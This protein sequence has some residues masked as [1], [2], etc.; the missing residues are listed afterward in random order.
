MG[1][2]QN[3]PDL[4]LTNSRGHP[5]FKIGES[6]LRPCFANRP[7]ADFS[8]V[9][10]S[11]YSK[12]SCLLD[13]GS[14]LNILGQSGFSKIK[15]L[16]IPYSRKFS[17]PS[18]RAV[19]GSRLLVKGVIQL[20]LFWAGHP[21]NC[22]AYI[23]PSVKQDL[24]LGYR[25][26]QDVGLIVDT[27]NDTYSFLDS[28]GQR[29][30]VSI[31][32][33]CLAE[34]VPEIAGVVAE[35]TNSFVTPQAFQVPVWDINHPNLT[36]S[37]SLEVID[38]LTNAFKEAPKGLGRTNVLVN[39][40]SL[41]DKTP[42]K[43]RQ[44]PLSFKA[45]ENANKTVD[46][47]LAL[48]CIRP[49]KSPF[50]NPIWMVNQSSSGRAD[51]LVLDARKLNERTETDCY[52]SPLMDR[53]LSS[54]GRPKFISK[55][56]L[57]KAFMQICLDE[58]SKPY[59]AFAVP[60]RGLFE[61]N[62][63]P[64]GLKNGPPVMQRLIE[65]IFGPEFEPHL[66][67]YLDDLILLSEDFQSHLNLLQTVFDRLKE[68]NLSINW[69]KSQFCVPSATF[70]GFVVSEEGVGLDRDRIAPILDLPAPNSKKKVKSFV[71]CCSFY[72]KH[73][74][75]FAEISAPLTRLTSAKVP[76]LWDDECQNSFEKLKQC[77]TSAPI[78]SNPI[79]G[80][81]WILET[82]ASDRSFGG[83]LLQEQ[84]G[85]RKII[86]YASK[87]FTD[88]QQRSW[89]TL[90]K[91][92]HSLL[93]CIDEKFR[94][95]IEFSEFDVY[96]DNYALSWLRKLKNPSGKLARMSYKLQQYSF[97]VFHK[98]GK[99]NLI[100]DLLSRAEY[101]ST[102]SCDSVDVDPAPEPAKFFQPVFFALNEIDDDWYFNFRDQIQKDPKSYKLFAVENG[103]VY[104]YY[105]IL[106]G[107]ETFVPLIP[108][109]KRLE[110][111]KL[112]H[113]PPTS[114]HLGIFKTYELVRRVGYWPKMRDTISKALR[115]CLVCQSVKTDRTLPAGEMYSHRVHYSGQTVSLDI[116]GPYTRSSKGHKYILTIVD[117]F[118]KW[119]V[120][121]PMKKATSYEVCKLFETR[122][123]LE[124]G[125]CH[126]VISDNGPQMCS[127]DFKDLCSKY[128][129][130]HLKTPRYRPQSNPVERTNQVLKQFIRSYVSKDHKKWDSH[131]VEF[132]FA[133]RSTCHESTGFTPSRLFL[134]REIALRG[135]CLG[136]P[137]SGIEQPDPTKYVQFQR[138]YEGS[139]HGAME[140]ART[141]LLASA[142]K[143]KKHYDLRRRPPKFAIGDLVWRTN[144]VLSKASDNFVASFAPSKVGPFV[145][146][147]IKNGTCRLKDLAG[148]DAGNWHLQDLSPYETE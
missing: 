120:F 11:R 36:M 93:W 78:L 40:I 54:V 139:L 24:I 133:I 62:V 23:I 144:H 12:L 72:R 56:D 79:K 53:I 136:F 138:D 92:L 105:G 18:V 104:H 141:S 96:T 121:L 116:M 67:S 107:K 48:G 83:T 99:D 42:F 60:G 91:E 7:M 94:P 30:T 81:K 147:E 125:A 35:P 73:I 43:C 97:N 127:R 47:W 64:F 21:V 148:Q 58:E 52:P 143:S 113:E 140:K 59:T 128:G 17:P 68:A 70:L 115:T 84:N 6:T 13:S 85:E 41:T 14:Q 63:T 142:D 50:C 100:P 109:N 103:F 123:I 111:I 37:Q 66:F 1:G 102:Y 55:I 90:E 108:Y 74:K 75:D 31:E 10:G 95:F 71:S 39:H 3:T 38:L 80:G 101:D 69:G 32:K 119:V 130:V 65:L 88:Q 106:N 57:N 135:D 29:R 117:L 25:F 87:K 146:S 137:M 98:R 33:S 77:L 126:T 82:D 61:F 2:L 15:E 34:I 44:Y 51:R 4:V 27:C 145:L 16:Q 132:A 28:Y 20:T 19:N 118:S 5:I 114:G 131:L 22:E 124:Y 26:W 9:Q 45:I 49:S 8:V 129:I 89:S 110:L 122:Y 46:E 76:F 86:A 112:Y 134:G